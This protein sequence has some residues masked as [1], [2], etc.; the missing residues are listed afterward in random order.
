MGCTKECATTIHV[1]AKLRTVPAKLQTKTQR[2]LV[3]D[4]GA[5]TD[6]PKFLPK[7]FLEHEENRKASL[8]LARW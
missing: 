4:C 6:P 2:V 3:S 1:V 7:T 5:M 8:D